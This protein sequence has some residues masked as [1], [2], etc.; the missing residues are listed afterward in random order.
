MEGSGP[1]VRQ[2]SGIVAVLDSIVEE[3]GS[4]IVS[5][6]RVGCPTVP[7]TQVQFKIRRRQGQGV[8]RVFRVGYVDNLD[9]VV[10]LR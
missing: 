2:V 6:A 10:V 1:G 7:A 3:K 9:A 5:K 8:E 4:V